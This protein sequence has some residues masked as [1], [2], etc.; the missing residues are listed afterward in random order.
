MDIMSMGIMRLQYH[1]TTAAKFVT[2]LT[3][4]KKMAK[5]NV[6]KILY[7]RTPKDHFIAAVDR[8]S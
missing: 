2:T 3:N 1:T 5:L 4:A 8:D 6:A 7:A